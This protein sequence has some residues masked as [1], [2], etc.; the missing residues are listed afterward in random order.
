MTFTDEEMDYYYPLDVMITGQD[1]LFFWIM[2]MMMSSAYLHNKAP[3]KKVLFN[4]IV[5]DESNKKMS[6]SLGN[7]I[8]PLDII[9]TI[10][11]DPMRFS[12]IMMAPKE[13]YLRFGAKSCNVGKTFCTK[14]WNVARFL[15]TN[16][17]FNILS[18][19]PCVEEF[20]EHDSEITALFDK[21]QKDII[22]C[23]DKLDYQRLATSLYTFTWDKFANYY[24]ENSKLNLT[25]NKKFI[26]KEIFTTLI[27]LLYPIIPHITEELWEMS[28]YVGLH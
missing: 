12:I 28:I 19:K 8:D 25:L 18:T 11:I 9:E 27:K 14:L 4:G 5:R 3:F 13:G 16:D 1:I 7:G 10:G 2:R 21:L 17:I 15:Q 23:Y 22:D 6:K 24:L 26:L 20:D